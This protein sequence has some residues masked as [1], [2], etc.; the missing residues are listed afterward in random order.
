MPHLVL[1]VL[2][3]SL[4][5][6]GIA[7]IPPIDRD[8]A[9]F[10]QATR[11]MLDTHD[12]VNIR[13]QNEPRNKKPV[14]IYWLQAAAVSIAGSPAKADIWP[15]RLPS[16]LG[17]M[18]AVFLTFAMGR[19]LF[20]SRRA[21]LAAGL[22]A[23]CLLLIVE[24]HQ[25]TTDAALLATVLATQGALGLLYCRGNSGNS[26]RRPSLAIPILFWA[27]QGVAILLKGPIVP[28]ISAV[29][30]AALLAADRNA[31]W[32]KG[33][34]PLSGLILAALIV[35]PWAI[36]VNRATGGAFF[37]DAVT[38]DLL[39]KLFSGQESHGFTPGYYLL[40]LPLTFWPA[41]AFI[42]LALHSAWEN[43]LS[44]NVRF[45]LAWIVPTW[46]IFELV[47]TKLPH[48]ALPMYPALALLTANAIFAV[49]EGSQGWPRY[50][51]SWLVTI[52]WAA[53]GATITASIVALPWYLD[54]AFYLPTIA[55]AAAAVI[56]IAL[57][58]WN[59]SRQRPV[60][61]TVTVI[62]AAAL[63]FGL[64]LQFVF[65]NVRALWLS[66]TV[67]ETVGELEKLQQ[68][69]LRV[70]SVGYHEPSLVFMLGT[71][72]ELVSAGK[73]AS[74]LA[75]DRTAL[76]IVDNKSENEF[77]TKAA[78]AKIAVRPI[79]AIRGFHY[80]KGRW[81]TLRFYGPS[82]EPPGQ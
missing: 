39:P 38:Q 74:I 50:W 64:S 57:A 49:R 52:V 53:T 51:P 37:H 25:A 70:V 24:A 62:I 76:V 78:E 67:E 14:G 72:T 17:A 18:A 43:R 46:I 23:S 54:N 20:D 71:G 19:K 56:C 65:P 35:C 75:Q 4:Y 66:R 21:L 61:S 27:A 42:G 31:R 3:A 28:L 58:V 7:A 47:P 60:E 40:L 16:V 2:C 68:A 48:Y 9:R 5:L 82:H 45:C 77:Q 63:I 36:A 44:R 6:P 73:A 59:L 22:L 30:I 1:L 15:Y 32:L 10:A 34:R 80:S 29:T 41:S 8:E 79:G 12:Y 13:F 33:L 81:V 69:P 11:Q 26:N 55:P